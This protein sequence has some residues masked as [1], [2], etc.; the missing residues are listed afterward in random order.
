MSALKREK[1]SVRPFTMFSNQINRHSR[2]PFLFGLTLLGWTVYGLFFAIQ[3]YF[4]QA[5]F[6]YNAD[7]QKNLVIWLTCAYSWA[8]LTPLI[9][10]LARRFPFNGEK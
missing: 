2:K 5:Y 1:E 9:L 7:F 4:R 8:S 3:S 10:V 6:G